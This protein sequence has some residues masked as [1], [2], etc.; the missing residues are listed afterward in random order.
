M[1]IVGGTYYE[2]CSE[3]YWDEIYGSGFRA[4]NLIL[5]NFPKQKI[6]FH[7]YTDAA[8][9]EHLSVFDRKY[10]NLNLESHKI[11]RCAKFIYDHPLKT[12]V[13]QP[14]PDVYCD[15]NLS[16]TAANENTL[17]FGMI[18]ADLKIMGKKVVYDPQSPAN[19]KPFASNGSKA[20][21]LIVVVNTSEAR[22]LAK[23]SDL[24]AI[25]NYFFNEEGCEAC[26]IKMGAKGAMLF[27]SIEDDPIKIPVFKTQKVWPI[28]SGDVFSTY[29]AQ[30]WFSGNENL[31]EC[32]V[33]ASKATAIYCES[34]KLN[35]SEDLLNFSMPELNVKVTP[36]NQVY[37]AGPFF[38]FSQRWLINEVRNSLRGFGV[39][40]FSPM[41][42]V[43][44]GTAQDVALP[45]LMGIDDSEVLIAIVDGL[46]SGTIFEIGYAIAKKKKVI[47]FVQNEGEESLKMLDGSGC[48][49]ER[50][51][52]TAI[53]K[54]YWAFGG[55]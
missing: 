39:K 45:D 44:Y 11:F 55:N 3:L 50:D 36:E 31:Q 5:E 46:D 26:I 32:A 51:L 38:T 4:V 35:I 49:I 23:S 34:K 43:G 48:S 29:F 9:S 6:N 42:D 17:A 12:P 18:E 25:K 24:S 54:T 2:V 1:N 13:I 10:S 7:T 47:V 14:R 52:S 41:H 30:M 22:I 19:P 33:S 16:I 27:N 15:M 28:G 53:Y 21:R 37:L 20:E 40:V 8:V